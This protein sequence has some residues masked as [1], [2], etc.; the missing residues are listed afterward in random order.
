MHTSELGAFSQLPLE[1]RRMIWLE[2]IKGCYV[3]E[4]YPGPGPF[5]YLGGQIWTRYNNGVPE[6]DDT[7]QLFLLDHAVNASIFHVFSL[8]SYNMT[9]WRSIEYPRERNLEK[10]SPRLL[11][12]CI[13]AELEDVFLSAHEF[14]FEHPR[15]LDIFLDLLPEH[16][17]LPWVS[18]VPWNMSHARPGTVIEEGWQKA[19]ARLFDKGVKGISFRF[20]EHTNAKARKFFY[21]RPMIQRFTCLSGVKVSVGGSLY[22]NM[23]DRLKSSCQNCLV[24]RLALGWQVDWDHIR[25]TD[26]MQIVL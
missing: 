19:F 6:T 20:D 26:L 10:L 1:V 17:Q 4:E 22:V 25:P 8:T 24:K 14:A 21:C 18:I 11:S 2:V 5:H 3:D 9:T 12:R 15:S 16:C 23:I 7:G 13:K